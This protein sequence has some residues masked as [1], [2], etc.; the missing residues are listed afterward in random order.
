MEIAFYKG[1]GDIITF[2]IR[3]ITRSRYSHT[4]IRFFNELVFQASGRRPA[5]ITLRPWTKE[6]EERWDVIRIPLDVERETEVLNYTM[7]FVG[8]QFSWLGLFRFLFPWLPRDTHGWF[9]T[10][11]IVHILQI[12]LGLLKDGRLDMT[13][14]ELYDKLVD[15][16]QI[17]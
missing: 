15:I 13:P 1:P 4:K 3:A 7:Q 16:Y 6:H 10:E 12:K 17:S 5:G 14:Q 8:G 11:I 9:C 2:L